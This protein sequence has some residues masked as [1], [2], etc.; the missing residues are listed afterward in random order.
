MDIKKFV[1]DFENALDNVDGG[2]LSAETKLQ[3][4]KQLDSLG[5]LSII[6]MMHKQYNTKIKG[7]D[8]KAAQTIADLYSLIQS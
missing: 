8:I 4:I 5:V 7:S 3:S 1:K 6:A 2:S